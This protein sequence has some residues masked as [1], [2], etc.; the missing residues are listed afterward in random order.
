MTRR[1]SRPARRREPV[2]LGIA[3]L[4]PDPAHPDGWTLLIDGV[5]Q[6]YVD[7]ADP[8]RLRFA[9]VRRIASVLDAAAAPNRP[10][11]VLHLGGGALTLPRYVAATRPG[12]AQ[13][14]VERDAALVA[15]VRRE[16]PLSADAGPRIDTADA[17]D[18][19]QRITDERYDVVVADVYRGAQLPAHLAGTGF[20]AEVARVLTPDGIYAVNLTDAPPLAVSRTHAATLRTVFADVC[21]IAD[22]ALLRGRRYGNVVFAA[23]LRPQRLPVAR[24]AAVA[25]RDPVAGRVLHGPDLDAFAVGARP[26]DDV[27]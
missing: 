25:R 10:L 9:Y 24:L 18:A 11:R 13:R 17:R 7:L 22:A 23:A 3:E 5:E 15:L 1:S 21:L 16:L 19:I 20:A 27:D 8:T 14:V 2:E 4:V 12:S 6:S 26:V